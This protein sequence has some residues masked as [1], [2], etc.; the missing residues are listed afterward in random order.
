MPFITQ[1]V[2]DNEG[3]TEIYRLR[4]RV[5]VEEWRFEKSENHPKGIEID[6]FDKS[7]IHFAAKD[8]NK[9]IIG[10]ICLILNST[11]GF[12]IEK[13][14]HLNI[15]RNE[16]LGE[17]LAEISMLT[18]SKN[19]RRRAEDRYV[20]GPDEE[21]RN[22]NDFN[23]YV[24]YAPKKTHWRS[25]DVYRHDFLKKK[26]VFQERRKRPE[27]I[28]SIYKAIYRESKKRGITQWYAVMAKG[29]YILLMKLGINFQPVGDP[30]D[31][32]GIRTPY[33]CDIKKIEHDISVKNQKLYEEFTEGL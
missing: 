22:F 25:E 17:N 33:L 10:T 15:N 27:I 30:V 26:R 14:C 7:S 31:Y 8:D 2:S 28:V 32:Y 23:N 13:H 21:R 6:A 18:I 24:N 5:Y 16:L 4:Y 9:K 19:Y 12:P 29:L 1:Q 3:L 11:D 20:Y